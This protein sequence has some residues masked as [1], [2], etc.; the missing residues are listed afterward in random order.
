MAESNP[1]PIAPSAPTPTLKSAQGAFHRNHPIIQSF[2]RSEV[3]YSFE[4]PPTRF[5]AP[6]ECRWC[7]VYFTTVSGKNKHENGV[8]LNYRPHRCGRCSKKFQYKHCLQKHVDAVHLGKRPFKCRICTRAFGDSSN[9]NKHQRR[10]ERKTTAEQM[11]RLKQVAISF[12]KPLE[13]DEGAPSRHLELK[14]D[15]R[16]KPSEVKKDSPS[17][18]LKVKN[19]RRSATK[20]QTKDL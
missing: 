20:K 10:C 2:F 1:A 16:S 13:R 5:L 14:S 12:G 18:P 11:L 19:N 6:N 7:G 17:T 3:R 15:S 4:F 8:H 9:R